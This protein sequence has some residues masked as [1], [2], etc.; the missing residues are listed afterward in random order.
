MSRRRNGRFSWQQRT[1]RRTGFGNGGGGLFS[2][3]HE[4]S[5]EG[6]ETSAH[7]LSNDYSQVGSDGHHKVLQGLVQ[8][9]TVLLKSSK[10]KIEQ[11]NL[12][13]FLNKSYQ[14]NYNKPNMRG[15]KQTKTI[16]WKA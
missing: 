16:R 9:S 5:R 8:L 15:P 7:K 12:L 1:P 14:S 3:V 10:F 2:E 6:E 4:A 13:N 11:R